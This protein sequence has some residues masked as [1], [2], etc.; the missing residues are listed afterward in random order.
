MIVIGIVIVIGKDQNR[1]IETVHQN[2]I[3][4]GTETETVIENEG[5]GM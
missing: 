2:V 4:T 1:G 5:E 3:E